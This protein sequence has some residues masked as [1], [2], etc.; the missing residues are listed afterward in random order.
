MTRLVGAS[1]CVSTSR[2]GDVGRRP[3]TGTATLPRKE[4]AP[5]DISPLR[6]EL[7][8]LYTEAFAKGYITDEALRREDAEWVLLLKGRKR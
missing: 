4:A 6:L 8:F 3:P 7:H 2:T 1:P 5:S